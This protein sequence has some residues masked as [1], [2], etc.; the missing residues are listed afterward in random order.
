MTK[1][2]LITG[3]SS[4]F[5]KEAVTLFQQKGWNVIATM[6]S[7]EK[8]TTWTKLSNVLVTRLDVTDKSS[9]QDAVKEGIE[10][11]GSIDVLVNNAGY[12]AMGAL[13]AASEEVIRQQFD[14]N[15]FGLIAVTKA[16]LPNMRQNKQG[17]IINVSSVGGKVTFPFSSLYHATKFAVE[18][19]TESL[20]YEL[21]PFGI[22]LKI[23][24]PGGYKTD[25]AGRSLA[26]FGAGD[27]AVYEQ[28]FRQL[29]DKIAT[30]PMSEKISEVAEAIYEATTDGSEKLRYP[31]GDDAI[32]L[33]QA[34]QHMDDI[35]MKSMIAEQMA[36]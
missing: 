8:E 13:E 2:V 11:F 21:S 36:D 27:V 35:A 7:P 5:G 6:R 10:K 34:R 15:L 20:Q 1:T 16:V 12:G 3:A 22:N 18:G 31:V 19:L 24:E 30:W 9:I 25:F 28:A 29:L 4:G 26:P 33:V 17:I 23:V 32:Q 14:V